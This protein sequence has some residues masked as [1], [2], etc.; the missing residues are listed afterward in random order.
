VHQ[1]LVTDEGKVYKIANQAK[2]LPQES[3][4]FPAREFRG[5]ESL[6]IWNRIAE[7]F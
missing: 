2:V 3:G 4:L 1:E 5:V 6:L 7:P